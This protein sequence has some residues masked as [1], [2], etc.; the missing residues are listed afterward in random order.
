MYNQVVYKS[1]V[2][3]IVIKKRYRNCVVDFFNFSKN[4][5]R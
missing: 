4:I 1:D 2:G 5:W 3:L